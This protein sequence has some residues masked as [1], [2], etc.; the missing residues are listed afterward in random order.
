MAVPGWKIYQIIKKGHFAEMALEG[1]EPCWYFGFCDEE[2][3]MLILCLLWGASRVICTLW[4]DII[5]GQC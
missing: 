5:H 3:V 1:F 4:A 2:F